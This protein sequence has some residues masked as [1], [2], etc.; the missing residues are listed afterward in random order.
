MCC[1]GNIFA[2]QWKVHP[3]ALQLDNLGYYRPYLLGMYM[4]QSVY[5]Y[6]CCVTCI[7]V[8]IYFTTLGNVISRFS[9][10]FSKGGIKLQDKMTGKAVKLS[11]DWG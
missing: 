5:S 11:S 9:E 10:L 2:E 1:H 7:A 6:T 8:I 3:W 4:H